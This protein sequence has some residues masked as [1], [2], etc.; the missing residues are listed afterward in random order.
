MRGWVPCRDVRGARLGPARRSKEQGELKTAKP[1]NGLLISHFWLLRAR[2]IDREAIEQPGAAGADQ[3]V[4]A[5]PPGGLGDRAR[6]D[7]VRW[8]RAVPAAVDGE[9]HGPEGRHTKGRGVGAS[10]GCHRG[11]PV[12]WQLQ[13]GRVTTLVCVP[14]MGPVKNNFT[15]VAADP[16]RLAAFLVRRILPACSFLAPCNGGRGMSTT[17][18]NA[19]L[20]LTGPH[21]DHWSTRRGVTAAA[22]GRSALIV[23]RSVQPGGIIAQLPSTR[24]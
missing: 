7:L 21:A 3:I 2:L 8:W 16:S 5:A 19:N 14:P 20:S 9:E 18:E 1:T 13:Q 23:G 15:F 24:E 17:P 12:H 4:L 11:A 10:G 6:L 22:C